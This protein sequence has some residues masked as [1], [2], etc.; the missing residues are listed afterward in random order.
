MPKVTYISPNEIQTVVDVPI[1]MTLMHGALLNNVPGLL[2][3]CGGAMLCA[4]CHV[5]LDLETANKIA[6]PTNLER[7]KLAKVSHRKSTSRLSCQIKMTEQL[8]GIVVRLPESQVW[9]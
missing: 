1:G 7:E 9:A 5:Y 8:D 3:E 6:M 4:T 2:A